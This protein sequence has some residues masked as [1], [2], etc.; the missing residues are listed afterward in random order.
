MIRP[1][2]LDEILTLA[3]LAERYITGRCN[4]NEYVEAAVAMGLSREQAIARCMLLDD[5]RART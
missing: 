3:S 2:T 1:P 5:G 4:D